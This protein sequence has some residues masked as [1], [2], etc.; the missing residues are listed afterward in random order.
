MSTLTITTWIAKAAAVLGGL[1]GDVTRRAH[2]VGQSRQ[3]LDRQARRVHD[4]VADAQRGRPPRAAPLQ[5][6]QRLR[7]EDQQLWGG[8]EQT[9]DFPTATQHQFTV[10]AAAMGLSLSQT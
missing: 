1:W 5:Q 7:H 8:L 2:D 3:A 9:I 10:T 4:A 6:L